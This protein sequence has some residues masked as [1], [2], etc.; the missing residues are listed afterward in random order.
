MLELSRSS[1]LEIVE[2]RPDIGAR[3]ALACLRVMATRLSETTDRLG[4]LEAAR[5]DSVRE[6]PT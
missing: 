1:F 2:R 3:L 6:E 4:M 5:F